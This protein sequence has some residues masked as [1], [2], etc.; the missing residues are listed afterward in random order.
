M[1]PQRH[2][3]PLHAVTKHQLVL[4]NYQAEIVTSPKRHCLEGITGQEPSLDKKESLRDCAV[5]ACE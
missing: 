5:G 1:R 4:E 3:M 2:L